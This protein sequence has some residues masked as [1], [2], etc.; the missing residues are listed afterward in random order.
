MNN[1]TKTISILLYIDVK[2]YTKRNVKTKV[3]DL[4]ETQLH[5]GETKT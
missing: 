5:K 4:L 3:V 1:D 2:Q